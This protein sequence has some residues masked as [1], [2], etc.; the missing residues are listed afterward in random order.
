MSENSVKGI[1]DITMEKV[2]AM[3][4]AD[5]IIGQPISVDGGITIIPVSKVSY[6]FASGGS[7]FG[8]ND[9]KTKFGGGGGAGVSISPTAFIVVKDNDVRLLQISKHP[10]PAGRAIDLM[11]DLFDKI[12]ALFKKDKE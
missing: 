1:M 6:G 12:T 5:S 10:D 8:A 7:D 11:P 4:D 2:R 3:A 9:A